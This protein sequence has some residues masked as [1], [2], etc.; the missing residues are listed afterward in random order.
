MQVYTNNELPVRE[1]RKQS[2]L[3]QLQNRWVFFLK[4][5]SKFRLQDCKSSA[6]KTYSSDERN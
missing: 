5:K 1:N 3:H 2:H 6:L 4:P